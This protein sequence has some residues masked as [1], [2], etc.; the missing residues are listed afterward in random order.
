MSLQID[1]RKNGESYEFL[2]VRSQ[3]EANITA[4]N[5]A[6]KISIHLREASP[7]SEDDA[8]ETVKS[9]LKHNGYQGEVFV[10]I[11]SPEVNRSIW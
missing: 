4:A 3:N 11:Y 6:V 9:F 5:Y 8:K 7:K 2:S 10:D 1:L